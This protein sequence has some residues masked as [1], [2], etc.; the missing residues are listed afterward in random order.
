MVGEMTTVNGLAKCHWTKW[1]VDETTLKHKL[2]PIKC[3]SLRM[4]SICKYATFL[5]VFKKLKFILTVHLHV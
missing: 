1:H 2:S 3:F 4:L 5:K